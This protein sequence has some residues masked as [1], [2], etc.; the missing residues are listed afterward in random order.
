[1]PC[2]SIL[3]IAARFVL[4]LLVASAL[5][6]GSL[7]QGLSQEPSPDY[8]T[9]R[10][11]CETPGYQV[12]YATHNGV[13]VVYAEGAGISGRDP[14]TGLVRW[15]GGELKHLRQAIDGLGKVL[16]IGEH[17]QMLSKERG[18]RL[19]DFPLNC[20]PGQCN[21]DVVARSE[22][23]L[24]IGGFGGVYNMIAPVR[25]ADGKEVWTSW[26]SVCPF[27]RAEL[28]E[29]GIILLCA[30]GGTLLQRIDLESRR[31]DFAQP[32][33]ASGFTPRRFWASSRHIFVEGDAAGQRK[34]AV[35]GTLDGK[36]VRSFKVK[37]EGDS[38]GFLVSPEEGRFVP[39]QR[40]D[41][42]WLA[43]GMDAETG[44]IVWHHSFPDA[45]LVGQSGAVQVLLTRSDTGSVLVGL[46]LLSGETA[47]SLPLPGA[48]PK[49]WLHADRLYVGLADGSFVVADASS[50]QPQHLGLAPSPPQATPAQFYVGEG[51]GHVVVLDGMKVTVY[52]GE[53]L[54]ERT[55]AATALLDDEDLVG[56]EKI[57]AA[58][59]PF[60]PLVPAVEALREDLLSYRF[61]AALVAVRKRDFQ[62]VEPL[63]GPWLSKQHQEQA[64]PLR[65]Y[66]QLLRVA[67]PLALVNGGEAD[68]LLL[69]ILGLLVE[70]AARPGFFVDGGPTRTSFIATA[71]ALALGVKS[72]AQEPS[73]F[74]DLRR[75][76]SIPELSA[77]L[78]GHPYWTHFLVAEVRSTLA[79]AQESSA[80]S[81]WKMAAE[82]LHDL[83]ALPMAARLFEATWDPWVDAQGAYLLPTDL[84]ARKVPELV[85]ALL[86]KLDK[87]A[88]AL[89]AETAQEVCVQR[90]QLAE[91]HCP[92][93]CTMDDECA[94]AAAACVRSCSKGSPVYI[95]PQFIMPPG[96]P[97]FASCR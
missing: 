86:K 79:A 74:A 2:P 41:G 20:F 71:V 51:N 80:I 9:D 55:A 26:L 29:D 62:A 11:V 96:S 16:L 44:K 27:T 95:P 83:A 22:T 4:T 45:R 68:G 47:Y 12:P 25:V 28:V 35:F 75:L 38:V 42:N 46:N 3:T 90:C 57:Y 6:L 56:A 49:A 89:L 67:L 66:S 32:P 58:L 69:E 77:L 19:W 24:L 94:K 13:E 23:L 43:W 1:M 7:S 39:W 17:I 63:I 72:A 31:T 18:Q 93:T 15:Q 5:A 88:G 91:R 60:L 37:E 97:G 78:E 76:H 50:G 61:L 30:S 33:P 73:A 85:A 36:P 14:K 21:A 53:R 8:L 81:E 87:G 70:R 10:Y 40:K 48:A 84:Q 59:A 65:H 52:E 54:D 64:A 34:L 92:G 82:L